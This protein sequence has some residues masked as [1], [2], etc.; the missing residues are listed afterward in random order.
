MAISVPV[1]VGQAVLQ[2][3]ENVVLTAKHLINAVR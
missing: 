3:I 2:M 1:A